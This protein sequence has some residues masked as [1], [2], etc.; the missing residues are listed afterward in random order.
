[1]KIKPRLKEEVKKYLLEK[2]QEEKN[3][4][5]ITSAHKLTEN[6]LKLI[7]D[8]VPEIRGKKIDEEIDDSLIAGVIIRRG[9]KIWDLSLKQQLMSL[10]HRVN[11]IA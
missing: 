10:Q 1:M 8:L 7:Q 3:K 5:V 2:Q 4:V 11:E 6:E 9:S